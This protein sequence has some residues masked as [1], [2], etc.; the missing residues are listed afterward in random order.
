MANS[1]RQIWNVSSSLCSYVRCL[2][3][4]RPAGNLPLYQDRE[5]LLASLCLSRNVAADVE[6]THAHVLVG[7]SLV[8]SVGDPPLERHQGDAWNS[9]RPASLEER[10]VI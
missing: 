2:D 5:G 3:D 1:F 7:Q 4:W 6:E 8:E 9:A 10:V